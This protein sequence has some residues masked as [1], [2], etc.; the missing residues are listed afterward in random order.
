VGT[1]GNLVNEATPQDDAIE[2]VPEA[3]ARALRLAGGLPRGPLRYLLRQREWFGRLRDAALRRRGLC[4]G[5]SQDERVALAA[6]A[7]KRGGTDSPAA[8]AQFQGKGEGEPGTA[9]ADWMAK[10]DG[11]AVDVDPVR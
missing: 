8:P 3:S 9:H 7:A 5:G 11:T 4:G 2:G 10:G 6:A 1:V